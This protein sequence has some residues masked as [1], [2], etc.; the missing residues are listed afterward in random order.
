MKYC[1]NCG[2]QIEEG[3]AYCNHCGAALNG[4]TPSINVTVNNQTYTNPAPAIPNRNIVLAIILS[5]VTC[6][7]YG[8]YWF[9]VMTDESNVVSGE[10]NGTSGI[11][12]FVFTLLTCGIYGLYWYYKMGQK[13]TKAGQLRGI[14][15]ADNSIIYLLLGLFGF[16]IV[17]YALIQNDLN[18]IAG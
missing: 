15:I 18:K 8:I 4:Q 10:T 7:I 12:S 9:I 14:N 3:I 16:G 17:C 2:N 1:P 11:L 13:M 6:G 5:I